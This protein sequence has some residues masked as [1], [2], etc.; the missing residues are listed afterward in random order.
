[1]LN[2]HA[3]TNV[4]FDVLACDADYEQGQGTIV[5]WDAV[6]EVAKIRSGLKFMLGR[7]GQDLVCEGNQ[8]FSEKCGIGFHGDAERRKVC[9]CAAWKCYAHAVVL[10]LQTFSSGPEVRSVA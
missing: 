8:Y 1:M 10:V 7:K 4:C 5:S 9:C 2:K 3:R 6:P